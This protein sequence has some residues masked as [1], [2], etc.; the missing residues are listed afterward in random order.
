MK[1]RSSKFART[2]KGTEKEGGSFLEAP[3]IDKKAK[4]EG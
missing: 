3:L 4:G 2:A 1:L